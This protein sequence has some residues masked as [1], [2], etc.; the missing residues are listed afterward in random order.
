MLSTL[1]ND[2]WLLEYAKTIRNY[3]REVVQCILQVNIV[4]LH[5]FTT[6]N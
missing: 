3:S 1:G 2:I 6:Y 5:T 4:L